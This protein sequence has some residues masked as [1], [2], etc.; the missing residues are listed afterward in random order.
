[1]KKFQRNQL[2]TIITFALW[3][4]FKFFCNYCILYTLNYK[5]GKLKVSAVI[6]CLICVQKGKNMKSKG[7]NVKDI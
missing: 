2:N 6:F 5:T 7:R 1:M 3:Q 4:N